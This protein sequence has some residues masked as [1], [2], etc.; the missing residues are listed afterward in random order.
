MVEGDLRSSRYDREV[1]VIGGGRAIVPM[2][3]WQIRARSVRK[4][5]L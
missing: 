5:V 3:S 2:K 1:D 4:L